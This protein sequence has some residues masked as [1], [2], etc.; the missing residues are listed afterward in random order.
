MD[1]Y[2][3]SNYN[4]YS[5]EE[6]EPQN[7]KQN[8]QKRKG[9]KSR[10]LVYSL[11][12]C[13]V[14]YWLFS[15]NRVTTDADSGF[16]YE[17]IPFV[18]EASHLVENEDKRVQVEK[19][20]R[21]NFLFLGMGGRTHQG[22]YLTDTIILASIELKTK[23]LAMV[24]IPRD[25]SVPVPGNGWRKVNHINAFAEM[26]DP[27]SGGEVASR[28]LGELLDVPIDYYVRVDFR[29]FEKI[30]NSLGGV[31]VYVERAFDDYSYP[32]H[33]NEDAVDY[34]SRFEHLHFDSGWKY[35][36]GGLALKYARSRHGTN[37]EGSD[38]ARAKRQQQVIKAVKE[39]VMSAEILKPSILTG[40]IDDLKHHISTNISVWKAIRLW[41][42]YGNFDSKSIIHE[43][44]DNSH[45]GLLVEMINEEGAYI[46]APKVG[47]FSQ[48][49]HLIK[50][51]FV[52]KKEE[53]KSVIES[54][55]PL[56]DIRNGT[57]IGGLA[58]NNAKQYEK[59]G[60]K[61]VNIGN[62]S[63]RDFKES[64]IYDLTYGEKMASLKVLKERARAN[65]SFGLPSWL[66]DELAEEFE[67]KDMIHEQP[68]FI[69]IIGTN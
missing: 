59:I 67:D 21:L 18:S 58:A 43:V 13:V 54:E 30:L 25:L 16:W 41:N 55:K 23:K 50:N 1:Q 53:Y 33:G 22:G 35:M 49:K 48:I 14:G 27:G 40:L 34:E 19:R 9:L 66:M 52:N 63:K 8:L 29:G 37:G 61:V 36:D 57:Y 31:N 32:V 24:S 7:L 44:L 47:D 65:V 68:D 11:I 39:R 38:F 15:N 60:F 28:V 26:D 64:V 5:K 4:K 62:A 51:I 56:V 46:L 6:N 10:V 2:R 69:L 20:D 45:D 17:K 3:N 12:F 42:E